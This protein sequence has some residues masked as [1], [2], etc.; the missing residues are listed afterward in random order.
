MTDQRQHSR[1]ATPLLSKDQQEQ[2]QHAL[3]ETAPD[4][5]LWTGR[6]VALWMDKQTRRK[7]YAERWMGLSETT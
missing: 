2:L 3:E 7:I 4:G 6:K 1:G 5:G